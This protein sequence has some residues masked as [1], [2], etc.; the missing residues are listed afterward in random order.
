MINQNFV[1]INPKDTIKT[2]LNKFDIKKR[3]TK[4]I[5]IAIYRKKNLI[6]GILSL[7]DVRR[8][9]IK[10]DQ[11][12]KIIKLINKKPV[13]LQKDTNIKNLPNQESSLKKIYQRKIDNVIITDK[14]K[15]IEIKKYEDIK[16]D[17][18]FK[19]ICIVGLGH[20]GLP[21]MAHIL[22]K[23]KIISGYDYNKQKI[24][25]IKKNKI[26]FFEPGLNSLLKSHLEE[27]KIN[28][29]N[30]LSKSKSNVYIICI[31][32]DIKDNKINSKNLI[33][34][35]K[36][37]SKKIYKENI[38]IIRGT[39]QVGFCRKIAKPILEKYSKLKAGKDFYISHMP[40]RIVEG[41]ALAELETLP[42]LVSGFSS[43]CLDEAL[44]FSNLFFKN[45]VGLNTLEESELIKLVSNSYRDLNFAFSNQIAKISNLLNLSGEKLIQKANM[46]YP[47]N[48]I[49]RPSLGVGGYCL[50]KDTKLLEKNLFNKKADYDLGKSSRKINKDITKFWAKKIL[51]SIETKRAKILIFGITFK[52]LPE[53]IDI[54]NS[55]SVDL[56]KI[57]NKKHKCD[58]FDI[59]GKE[60]LRFNYKKNIILNLKNLHNYDVI[61]FANNNF[62]YQECFL[63]F[64]KKNHADSKKII[65]DTASVIDESLAISYNYKYISI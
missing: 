23:K 8:L 54:R 36:S 2:I 15:I 16:D 14:K 52:G 65:F 28:L 51:S 25:N 20:I 35:L 37:I 26:S 5:N 12:T 42:Q 30:N 57:L 56:E 13:E 27:K 4:N 19:N 29:L 39:T 40:E 21:L 7:G 47:R 6:N 53:T 9:V 18:K 11:D 41:N 38:I 22:K 46:G 17:I 55:P 44:K 43:K 50:P 64:V 34:C 1:S 10:Y 62:K 59:K 45:S 60:I 58:F 63:K 49:A 61:I 33:S 24:K 48:L 31:G 32:Q 3:S